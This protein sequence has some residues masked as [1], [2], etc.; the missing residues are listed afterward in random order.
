M[1]CSYPPG[2]R[3][4]RQMAMAVQTPFEFSIDP[5]ELLDEQA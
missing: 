1:N 4:L 3:S 2:S 5:A